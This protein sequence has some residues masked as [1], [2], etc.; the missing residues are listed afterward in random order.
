MPIRN[1]LNTDAKRWEKEIIY[2][3]SVRDLGYW[4][5]ERPAYCLYVEYTLQDIGSTLKNIFSDQK[6]KWLDLLDE[7]GVQ[8]D[9]ALIQNPTNKNSGGGVP[10]GIGCGP[11]L[12]IFKIYMM[13]CL[14]QHGMVLL[15]VGRDAG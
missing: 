1:V 4:E 7:N 15:Q 3:A 12:K 10:M 5:E 2:Y 6:K 8:Y 11:T 9:I 14:D 13:L